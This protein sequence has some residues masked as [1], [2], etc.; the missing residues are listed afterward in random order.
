MSN[1]KIGNSTQQ[2]SSG[3]MPGTETRICMHSHDVALS[4]GKHSLQGTEI[5]G[6]STTKIATNSLL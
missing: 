2:N 1:I 6:S 3:H 5:I 4:L